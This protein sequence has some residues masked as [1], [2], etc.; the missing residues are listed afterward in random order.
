MW[1]NVV[2]RANLEC[3]PLVE[4]LGVLVD[5]AVLRLLL[6]RGGDVHDLELHRA[7]RTPG[8]KSV[9]LSQLQ[10]QK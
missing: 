9:S 2:S 10:T 7:H 5:V 6:R 4:D 8:H 1:C 3:F